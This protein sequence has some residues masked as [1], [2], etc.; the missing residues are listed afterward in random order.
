MTFPFRRSPAGIATIAVLL[1]VATAAC[2]DNDTGR[3]NAAAPAGQSTIA[4]G[5][6][7]PTPSDGTGPT[8][9]ATVESAP[10]DAASSTSSTEPAP[11]ATSQLDALLDRRNG[12]RT[13]DEHARIQQL[14][15]ECMRAEGFEYTPE[16]YEPPLS[17]A[18]IAA[19]GRDTY[20]GYG[21]VDGLPDLLATFGVEATPTAQPIAEPPPP[22]VNEPAAD[23]NAAY[24][25]GLSPAERGA[26]QL[27]LIGYD[28]TMT[29]LG[30]MPEPAPACYDKAI[31]AVQGLDPWTIPELNQR[32]S[33]VNQTIDT[34]PR[35]RRAI[36][37][38]T[39]CVN[40]AFGDVGVEAIR[41]V[42]LFEWVEAQAE[43]A[44]GVEST[45]SGEASSLAG[46]PHPISDEEVQ[47][48]A[49]LE[50]RAYDTDI[51]CRQQAGVEA[52]RIEVEN[53]VAEQLIAEFPELALD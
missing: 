25:A 52:A 3:K 32:L 28:P 33:D 15:A 18:E 39:E 27:A 12:T 30:D 46:T 11:V 37:A 10:A 23:P 4:S 34:D 31:V 1:G 42:S 43:Q 6:T 24:L 22:P 45:G 49:E 47:R 50:L 21:I 20:G 35:V 14:I 36:D 29:T 17:A 13:T 16:P 7:A 8:V 44:I 41:E 19:I 51:A 2:T 53:E 5:V 40:A 38:W 9:A 48:L 26:Y